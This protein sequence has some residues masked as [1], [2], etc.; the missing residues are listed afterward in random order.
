LSGHLNLNK[1]SHSLPTK[2]GLFCLKLGIFYRYFKEILRVSVLSKNPVA[3]M[4]NAR[5]D[6]TKIEAMK[7]G[8]GK[9]FYC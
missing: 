5:I 1:G 9:D 8:L 7:K 4:Q 3:I 2:M 6:W